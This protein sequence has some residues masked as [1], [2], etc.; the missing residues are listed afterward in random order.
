MDPTLSDEEDDLDLPDDWI[1][2]YV[3][4]SEEPQPQKVGKGV[5]QIKLQRYNGP[6][7]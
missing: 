6:T 2:R 4:G 1:D 5:T 7:P 3:T